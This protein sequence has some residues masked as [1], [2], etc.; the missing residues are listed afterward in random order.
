MGQSSVGDEVFRRG[1]KDLA[2]VWM[3]QVGARTFERLRH[4]LIRT[5]VSTAVERRHG[6]GGWL[7]RRD[8]RLT[9]TASS[10]HIAREMVSSVPLPAIVQR[11][12]APHALGAWCAQRCCPSLHVTFG[13][14]TFS[15]GGGEDGWR[16]CPGVLRYH[17]RAARCRRF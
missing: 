6:D 15:R 4:R 1:H 5:V 11:R 16:E 9:A 7:D 10:T 2:R 13:A 8:G 14:C 12:L 3:T 17:R